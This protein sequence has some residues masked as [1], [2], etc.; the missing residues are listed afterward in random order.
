M[1]RIPAGR[2]ARRD[3]GNVV[4]FLAS[5]ASDYI[6]GQIAPGRRRLRASTGFLEGSARVDSVA[7]A[8]QQ[9]PD[10]RLTVPSP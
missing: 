8:S 1:V 5:P 7:L 6:H 2:W 4:V 9:A 10:M 3:I